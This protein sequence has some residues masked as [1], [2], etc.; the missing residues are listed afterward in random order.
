VV[1]TRNFIGRFFDPKIFKFV[2]AGML[3]TAFGYTVYAGLLFFKVSYLVALFVATIAGVMFNYFS[4]GRIVFNGYG[5]AVVFGKFVVAYV[6]IYG[7]NAALLSILT[8]YFLLSPYIGQA[9]CI[10]F[11]VVLSWILM[12]HWVYKK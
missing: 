12:N 1:S 7:V 6:L 11:G 5:G 3:N 9:I 8:N 2:S 10:P 4:F